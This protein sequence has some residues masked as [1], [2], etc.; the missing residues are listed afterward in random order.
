ME[1]GFEIGISIDPEELVGEK[2]SVWWPKDKCSYPGA[3]RAY[4]PTTCLH[5]ASPR[6]QRM[7]GQLRTAMQPPSTAS[8]QCTS[9]KEHSC[10]QIVYED[11]ECEDLLLPIERVELP[12]RE[13]AWP[14]P[15][16]PQLVQ[17]QVVIEKEVE[18][19]MKCFTHG[20]LCG[21][22]GGRGESLTEKDHADRTMQ[23]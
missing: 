4:S 14:Q 15:S 18:G 8:R 12:A 13:T 16:L 23:A 6:I 1:G 2:L 3:V 20:K 17:L 5:K 9:C 22:T 10:V 11:G 21:S 7:Q 19:L